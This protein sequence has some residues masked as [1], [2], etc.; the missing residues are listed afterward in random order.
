MKSEQANGQRQFQ[1]WL[2]VA[3]LA[4]ATAACN[5][6]KEEPKGAD[7][8]KSTAKSAQQ[9][10]VMLEVCNTCCTVPAGSEPTITLSPGDITQV[11]NV[12]SVQCTASSTDADFMVNNELIRGHYLAVIFD[13]NPMSLV[14][15]SPPSGPQTITLTQQAIKPRLIRGYLGFGCQPSVVMKAPNAAIAYCYSGNTWVLC[16]T[17]MVLLNLPEPQKTYPSA[18]V[19]LDF[20]LNNATLGANLKLRVTIP[21]QLDTLIDQ[22]KPFRIKNLA[23]GEYTVTVQLQD[24]AGNTIDG[25]F[26][27][28]SRTFKVK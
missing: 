2:L 10:A 14:S 23:A 5:G 12:F 15:F 24:N 8:T 22:N 25:G 7:T 6:K 3:A 9:Q 1:W 20:V 27:K 11:G 19:P 17:P 4:L 28:S 13:D 21:E 16:D 18:D 26:T